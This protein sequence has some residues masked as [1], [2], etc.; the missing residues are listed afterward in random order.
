MVCVFSPTGGP[1]I[2]F[3]IS[4][5]GINT[6]FYNLNLQFISINIRFMVAFKMAACSFHRVGQ[7]LEQMGW[8]GYLAHQDPRCSLFTTRAHTHAHAHTHTR[9]RAHTHTHTRAHTRTHTHAHTQ[10][11][12]NAH[13]HTHT[14][15]SNSM[16]INGM[17]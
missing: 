14:Q 1:L 17:H 10:T 7:A 5:K 11:H 9:T 15:K 6:S 16:Q 3:V 12:T 8:M 13:A 2:N 4:N